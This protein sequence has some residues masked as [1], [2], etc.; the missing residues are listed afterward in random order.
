MSSTRQTLFGKE[1]REK[2]KKGVDHIAD[3]V[4]VTLGAQGRHVIIA[5]NIMAPHPTKDGVTVARSIISS[6]PVENIGVD[7]VREVASKTVDNAGDGTTTSVVLAQSLIAGCIEAINSGEN[8]VQIKKELE[9]ATAVVVSELTSLSRRVETDEELINIGTISAN[10]DP[11]IGGLIAEVIRKVGKD[12]S[13][14]V[15]NSTNGKTEI[16]VVEGMKVDSGFIEPYFITNPDKMKAEHKDVQIL[17]CEDEL[18]HLVDLLPFLDSWNKA[19]AKPLL[20]IAKDVNGEALGTIIHSKIKNGLPICAIRVPGMGTNKG[21]I[22]DDIATVTGGL[23]VSEN[24][25]L[26][27][28]NATIEHAGK[29]SRF[30]CDKKQTIIVDGQGSVEKIE[31]RVTAL[32]SQILD[33]KGNEKELL[34]QRVASISNGVAVVLVAG[35]TDSEIKEKK[36]RIDD[37]ICATKS[38]LEEG[39]LAGGGTAYLEAASRLTF[40]NNGS[41][42]LGKA[43]YAPFLQGLDN[44]GIG[45]KSAFKYGEGINVLT[46]Q[47]CNLFDAG[48]IDPTKV[49]RVALENAVSVTCLILTTECVS[50]EEVEVRK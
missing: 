42:I 3:A 20:I 13:V 17:L 25:G 19:G 50:Y 1:A 36:D 29:A 21:Q 35:I 41:K 27:I 22:L 2:I 32:K 18:T 5:S 26:H 33:A 39:Y 16:V 43:L 12:G 15:E 14:T 24:R 37:A 6:D 44:A 28:K 45:K 30:V 46:G 10:N 31:Q 48:I 4:K 23:V 40:S 38:A 9:A 11:I 34:T 8:P 49:A 47:V 7:M